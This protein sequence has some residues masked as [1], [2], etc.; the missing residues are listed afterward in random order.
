MMAVPPRKDSVIDLVF[1]P[2]PATG[3]PE[4][5]PWAMN[6]MQM[7]IFPVQKKE[8]CM[9]TTGNALHLG[10]ARH[11]VLFNENQQIK[12]RL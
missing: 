9:A 1:L 4:S 2:R 6:F 10:T 5:K 8:F 7:H 12:T 11:V 3:G